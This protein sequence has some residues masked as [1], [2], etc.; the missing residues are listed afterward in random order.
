MEE[1]R[2]W[3]KGVGRLQMVF[4]Y[5]LTEAQQAWFIWALGLY[6]FMHQTDD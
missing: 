2:W 1:W 5:E 3:W 6:R 4:W